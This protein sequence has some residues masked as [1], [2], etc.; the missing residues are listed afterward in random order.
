M[1]FV[2]YNFCIS[3]PISLKSVPEGSID[4]MPIL[5]QIMACRTSDKPLSEPMMTEIS[6]AYEIQAKT[7]HGHVRVLAHMLLSKNDSKISSSLSMICT[8]RSTTTLL[9]KCLLTWIIH[10]L[11]IVTVWGRVTHCYVTY[12][13][14]TC[15]HAIALSVLLA[16]ARARPTTSLIFFL[17]HLNF[18]MM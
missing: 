6:D 4:N 15:Y 18:C 12:C 1:H 2:E 17:T 11:Q 8:P 3:I 10:L 16:I 5:V 14:S 13:L 7:P 9:C